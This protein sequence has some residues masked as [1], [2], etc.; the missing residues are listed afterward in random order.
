MATPF[1]NGWLSL[2]NSKVSLNSILP[3]SL[4]LSFYTTTLGILYQ[5]LIEHSHPLSLQLFMDP[6]LFIPFN[7]G[8]FYPQVLDTKSFNTTE[9]L[10]IPQHSGQPW[11]HLKNRCCYLRTSL[12]SS[13]S[14]LTKSIITLYVHTCTHVPQRSS[15]QGIT[16]REL[17]VCSLLS[18]FRL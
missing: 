9:E 16:L 14:L 3:N 15:G 8:S 4:S 17:G 12:S 10:R 13:L 1:S 2:H 6:P 7:S 11:K 18:T 5:V